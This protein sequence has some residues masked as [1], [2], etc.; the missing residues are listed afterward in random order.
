MAKR[1]HPCTASG[2][3]VEAVVRTARY[4]VYEITRDCDAA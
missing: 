1:H 2:V 4:D 3:G